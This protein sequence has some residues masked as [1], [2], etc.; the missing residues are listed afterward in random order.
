MDAGVLIERVGGVA[1]GAAVLAGGVSSLGGSEAIADNVVGKALLP[2]SERLTA[3]QV[4]DGGR[5]FVAVVVAVLPVGAILPRRPGAAAGGI[6]EVSVRGHG[7]GLAAHSVADAFQAVQRVVGAGR[8]HRAATDAGAEGVL[9]LINEAGAG[10]IGIDRPQIGRGDGFE[11]P[12]AVVAVA[13][14]L[15]GRA[16]QAGGEARAPRQS[17]GWGE[18]EEIPTEDGVIGKET[19][20]DRPSKCLAIK[21]NVRNFWLILSEAPAAI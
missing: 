7:N 6:V 13:D 1:D 3:R 21:S 2:T 4:F 5:H 11:A 19:G 18:W 12:E 14:A 16:A 20:V 17:L 9:D 8:R 10:V 15:Q